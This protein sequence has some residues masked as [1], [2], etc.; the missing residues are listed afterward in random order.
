MFDTSKGI[1]TEGIFAFIGFLLLLSSHYWQFLLYKG[2]G[3][4]GGVGVVQLS[5]AAMLVIHLRIRRQLLQS[6]FV[7][8][9]F[10]FFLYAWLNGSFLS[11]DG[12]QYS[13]TK[14]NSILYLILPNLTYVLIALRSRNAIAK[15]LWLFKMSLVV[16]LFL[17]Y[18]HVGYD[19]VRETTIGLNPIWFARLLG[20]LTIFLVFDFF[21]R[22]KSLLL[23][24]LSILIIYKLIKAGSVGPFVSLILA[25]IYVAILKIRFTYQDPVYRYIR[26]VLP[27]FLFA[28][29]LLAF[30]SW[31]NIEMFNFASFGY[32]KT[33]FSFVL[34]PENANFF[35]LGFG[36][37]HTLG[38][39]AQRF[40]Y[41]HN[42]IIETYLELG[43]LGITLFSIAA[44]FFIYSM[45]IKYYYT[46]PGYNREILIL[47]HTFVVFSFANAMFS[48][49][50]LVGNIFL[51]IFS[52]MYTYY[53]LDLNKSKL[54]ATDR[55]IG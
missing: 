50:L 49:D 28:V 27:F 44:G 45:P 24:L 47:L 32:R 16:L 21:S 31:A 36:K 25:F 14:I 42:I 13:R 12:N 33:M 48:G 29:T 6:P 26:V 39:L 30:Y 22:G 11:A 18:V 52:L 37:F 17:S 15:M 3:L 51:Y 38:G 53:F 23:S 34:A 7:I 4:G 19:G 8:F 46:R 35:G 5:L 10:I 54:V 40:F 43:F 55:N 41:P 1:S 2:F 9:V 20:Y